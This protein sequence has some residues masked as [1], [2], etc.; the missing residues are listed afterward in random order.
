MAQMEIQIDLGS[1]DLDTLD[2]D[3]AIRSA[4]RHLVPKALVEIGESAAEL[5]WEQ[6]QKAFSGTGFKPNR[7]SLDKRQFI[8]RAGERYASESNDTDRQKIEDR[9]IEQIR[10][11]R[12]S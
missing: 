4:A 10:A 3:E 5:I 8:E 7:S 2:S 1:L 9:I 11:R 12:T 6:T